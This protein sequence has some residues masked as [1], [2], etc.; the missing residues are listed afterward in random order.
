MKKT[1]WTI[2]VILAMAILAACGS[3]DNNNTEQGSD[4]VEEELK[5]IEVDFDVPETAEAG[6]TVN[7]Q[8]TVTYGDEKVTDAEEMEFEYWEKGKQ[9]DSTMVDSTNNGDGTYT[10]EVTFD[11]DGVYEIYAHTTARDMHT[12]PKKSITIGDGADSEAENSD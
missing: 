3:G 9:D 8:A 12:M 5:A 10:A 1:I 4:N 2:L 6:E 7:L 11:Q